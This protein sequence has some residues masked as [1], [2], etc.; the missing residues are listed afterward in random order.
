[1]VF[2]PSR[3]PVEQGL[4]LLCRGDMKGNKERKS[5]ILTEK[6]LTE[7]IGIEMRISTCFGDQTRSSSFLII[8]LV[9]WKRITIN[10]IN[11]FNSVTSPS[12]FSFL[13]GSNFILTYGLNQW[14]QN[15]HCLQMIHFP[16]WVAHGL[17]D[18][19]VII[20]NYGMK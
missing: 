3:N 19:I 5:L 18:F 6:I 2:I 20:S 13:V 8:V 4:I 9:S 11:V 14:H 1:M 16:S 7:K 12:V 17:F 15:C 10:F